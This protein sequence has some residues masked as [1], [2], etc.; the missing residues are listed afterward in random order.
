[1]MIFCVTLVKVLVSSPTLIRELFRRNISHSE[2]FNEVKRLS[3][4]RLLLGSVANNKTGK[5]GW[6]SCQEVCQEVC[7]VVIFVVSLSIAKAQ[8]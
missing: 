3:P 5:V 1:M 7:P 6:N 8:N 2:A 4:Q